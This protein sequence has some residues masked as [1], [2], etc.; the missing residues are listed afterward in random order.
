MEFKNWS[1][2]VRVT[3]ASFVQ[4]DTVDEVQDIVRAS[5]CIRAVGAGHSFTPVAATSGTLLNLDRLSGI[6]SADRESG[7]VRF[8]GGTRLRDI[9]ALL[10]P[11]GLALANQGDI[12]AQSLA[13]A[14]STGT[15]GTGLQ[16]TGFAG[17]V[18]GVTIVNASGE[19]VDVADS[20]PNFPFYVVHLGLLGILVEIE[21][22]CVPAFDIIAVEEQ[23]PL[24]EI[25]ETFVDRAKVTDHVEF[26]WFPHSEHVLLKSNTRVPGGADAPAELSGAP[27]RSRFARTLSEEV[28][29]NGG[30]R[31][32]LETGSR[33]PKVVPTI[34]RI[35]TKLASGRTYRGPAHEA[36]VSPRRV[37]FNEM[38]YAVPAENGIAA[39]TEIRTMI[40]GGDWR[41]S[42]P[43][44]VRIAGADTVP[45][46]TAY[47]RDSTYI[48]VHR[49]VRDPYKEYF[50]AV[51]EILARHGGRPHWGKIHSR[52]SKYLDSAYPLL[53]QF[54]DLVETTDPEGRFGTPYLDRIFL[55]K[56]R[57]AVS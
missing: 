8:R 18:T 51:E 32:A 44:E 38:E 35:A 54:R 45:L 29:D 41:I 56:S 27:F 10:E 42:F 49:F 39:F 13:G 6:V 48:A 20:D 52:S 22:Q 19:L 25:E 50:T 33:F 3:P 26:F 15:H 23:L 55:G 1:G 36:F 43:I 9:P 21:I 37:R 30:L 53:G 47:G 11:Y 46:S 14:V 4:P 28:I 7:R 57:P 17:M 24:A 16:F 5:K 2:S 34:N 40:D 31:V 12:N